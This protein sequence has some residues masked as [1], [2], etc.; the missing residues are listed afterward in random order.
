MRF[1]KWWAAPVAIGI[2]STILYIGFPISSSSTAVLLGALVGAAGS[3]GAGHLQRRADRRHLRIAIRGEILSMADEIDKHAQVLHDEKPNSNLTIPSDPIVDSVYQSNSDK[4]GL[5]SDREVRKVIEFYSRCQT[6][7]RRIEKY[8][9]ME[10]I[11]LGSAKVF[12]EDF[13]FLQ[14]NMKKA[15]SELEESL[16]LE[17]HERTTH[18][19]YF[20]RPD[21]TGVSAILNIVQSEQEED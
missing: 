7:Q 18:L 19:C 17:D 3:I 16:D 9:Q 20:E 2:L 1:S 11:P 21:R 13:I 10:E 5:L 4:L 14:K 6:I 12:R 8:S 15:L